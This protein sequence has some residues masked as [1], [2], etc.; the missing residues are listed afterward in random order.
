MNA[1]SEGDIYNCSVGLSVLYLARVIGL[2]WIY[3][4][5]EITLINVQITDFTLSYAKVAFQEKW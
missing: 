3:I 2:S 4:F 5:M 1:I